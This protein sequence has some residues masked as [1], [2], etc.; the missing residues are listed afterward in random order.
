MPKG[1]KGEKRPADVIANAVLVMKIATGQVQDDIPDAP[2]K[3]MTA[4]EMGKR[5]GQARAEN[6]SKQK[7]TQ[8]AK[9][10]AKARWTKPE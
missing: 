3:V 5:G 6:L 2:K 1:P 9:R 10:A 8:I 4:S 7:R